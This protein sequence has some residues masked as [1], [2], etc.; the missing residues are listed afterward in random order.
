MGTRSARRSR[1]CE[2][3][4]ATEGTIA[5]VAE[6]PRD[7]LTP[8]PASDPALEAL[9]AQMRAIAAN[10]LKGERAG[11]TLQATALVHEAWMRLLDQRQ[12]DWE[13]PSRVL[14]IA[15]QMMRR[16]L[17]DHARAR[18][19]AKRGGEIGRADVSDVADSTPDERVA[20]AGIDLLA[21]EEALERLGEIDSTLVRLV[22]L[23][24]F[25]GLPLE[26]VADILGMPRRSVDRSWAAAR[27]WLYREL[28]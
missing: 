24:F 5:G 6:S 27:A 12:L 14:P 11:H 10:H 23:R 17:V 4:P 16:I 19:T 2:C 26:Q 13:I 20:L 18:T 7:P 3:R 28:G 22:E 1:S 25:A 15:A 9:Y 21:L 8:R